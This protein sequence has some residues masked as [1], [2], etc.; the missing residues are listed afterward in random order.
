MTILRGTETQSASSRLK[1]DGLTDI[2]IHL[3]D[4]RER[5]GEH[6][7]HAIIECKRVADDAALCR[8]YV[9]CGIDRFQSGKYG[10]GHA[11]GFMVG[12][13][14]SGGVSAAVAKINR[15]LSRLK[16]QTEYLQ[17]RR[18]V[19]VAW[20]WF[21]EHSRPQPHVNIELHHAFLVFSP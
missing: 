6:D 16:R 10:I 4:V 12:Y 7:P 17:Q 19:G 21:S 1:P 15:R 3:Q 18:T 9:R 11:T 20:A 2:S 5:Y 13:V 14:I 8:L